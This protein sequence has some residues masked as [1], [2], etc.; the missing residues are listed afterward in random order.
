MN[1]RTPL[2][3]IAVVSWNNKD[4]IGECLD[5][6]KSQTYK[7]VYTVLLDNNSNDN[8]VNFVEKHY[9]WVKILESNRNLGFC[10][11]NNMIIDEL[12]KKNV[13]Y[14]L[15]LNSDARLDKHWLKIILKIANDAPDGAM[16]QGKTLDYYN[17]K[18]IDSKYVFLNHNGQAIQAGFR[19]SNDTKKLPFKV[20]GVNAA[21]CLISTKYINE[22]PF[23]TL[24]DEDLFMY[25][26]DVDMS[27][28]A[29][30]IGWDNYYV[31]EAIA[32][33]MGSASS[34]KNP[35]FSIYMVNRNNSALIYKNLPL[36]LIIKMIP[37]VIISDF[38]TIIHLYR[39]KR[40]YLIYKFISG[41]FVGL[42]ILP[43]YIKKR[44]QI[45]KLKKIDSNH[46][47][48]LMSKGFLS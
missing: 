18:V 33:H 11:G 27:A 40:L 48:Q 37:K 32:Y 38:Q 15:L 25:L 46:L 29:T 16:F 20:F 34:S 8:T 39:G 1:N 21:A 44:H 24:F 42:I 43:K 6:I 23:D 31:P 9:S 2:V 36:S 28:R 35:G 3:G 13:D 14:I 4:I 22:Q 5:S 7:E 30:I 10:K 41:R 19:E 45:I 12:L 47:W 26:E 17:H